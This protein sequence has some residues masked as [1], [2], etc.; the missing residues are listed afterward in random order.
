MDIPT[1]EIL[2]RN[3]NKT[4]HNEVS[5]NAFNF[6][7][8]EMI[9]YSQQRVSGT[10]QELEKKLSDFGY[11]VGIRVVELLNWREKNG[12]REI[13]ILQNLYFIHTNVWKMLFGKQADSLEKHRE[14]EDEYMISDNEPIIT[15]YISVPKDYHS[16]ACGAFLAGIVEAI[17]D[18][19]QLPAKVEAYANPQEGFPTKT[20][21]VINFDQSVIDRE[22]LFQ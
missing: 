12:K 18:G 19:A 2:N 9:Q 5:L 6:L 22:K 17:L 4:R 1:S 8:S 15:K 16:L 13:K 3:L 10:V 14:K 11:R 21:I 7:F 20:T